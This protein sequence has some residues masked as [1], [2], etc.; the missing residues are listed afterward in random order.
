MLRNRAS[1]SERQRPMATKKKTGGK[2][3]A[4]ESPSLTRFR[5]K[6]PG[7]SEK[8]DNQK[9]TLGRRSPGEHR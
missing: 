8:Q 4:K 7:Q 3:K 6:T 5:S 1:A 2:M 9:K